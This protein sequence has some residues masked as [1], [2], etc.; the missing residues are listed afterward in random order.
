MK[1][2]IKAVGEVDEQL[3]ERYDNIE[4]NFMPNKRH[5]WALKVAVFAACFSLIIGSVFAVMHFT[6][7][8][9]SPNYSDITSENESFENSK[10]E[11]PS[12]TKYESSNTESNSSQ[13]DV[14]TDTSHVENSN[15]EMSS[16]DV[17]NDEVS[18]GDISNESSE[19]E[20]NPLF[21][22]ELGHTINEE[23]LWFNPYVSDN[24][25]NDGSLVEMAL[26]Y[27]LFERGFTAMGRVKQILPDTYTRVGASAAEYRYRI[28]IMSIS[29]SVYGK[30]S[31]ERNLSYGSEL[32]RCKCTFEL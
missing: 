16:S 9:T 23:T 32:S 31:S 8:E 6:G 24:S 11:N 17:S 26:P 28:L 25:Q 20:D 7:K 19:S 10:N 21:P 1:K 30:K 12:Q 3:L 4:K 18:G 2:F 29:E 22:T 5:S 13:S 27:V 14:S 15:D